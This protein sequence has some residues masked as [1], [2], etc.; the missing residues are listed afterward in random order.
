MSQ[1]CT[2]CHVDQPLSAF[3]RRCRADGT[4]RRV[5]KACGLVEQ[6]AIRLE[7]A[8]QRSASRL[9]ECG[10][11]F[12]TLSG[13]RLH[14]ALTPG[15]TQS[16]SDYFWSLVRTGPGCWEWQGVRGSKGYGIFYVA[17]QQV[18]AHR[19]SYEATHGPIPAGLLICHHCDNPPCVR[20]DH[21]FAG[22]SRENRQDAIAK[23][24]IRRAAPRVAR[25]RRAPAPRPVRPVRENCLYGHPLDRVVV[26]STGSKQRYCGTCHR[27]HERRRYERR[28]WER[29]APDC[30]KGD[31]A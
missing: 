26:R 15:C 5:C 21:L 3:H 11:T 22:T 31:A 24:R 29:G 4:P 19:F 7:R 16:L 6:R 2:R 23:G 17:K 18:R 25:P 30:V 9:C 14:R 1:T 10:G 12:T 13:L 20:P 27:E 8:R 28:R